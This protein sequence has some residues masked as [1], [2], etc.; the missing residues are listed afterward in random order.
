MPLPASSA[1]SPSEN[2]RAAALAHEYGNRCGTE[3]SP[4]IEVTLAMTP[5]LRLR[6]PGST[7]SEPYTTPQKS[8]ASAS[9]KSLSVMSSSG[10][11]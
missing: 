4:P 7:A 5:L 11:A 9:R 10:P 2:E 8:M 3:T 1:V 6:M